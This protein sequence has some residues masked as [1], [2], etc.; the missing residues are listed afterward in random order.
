MSKTILVRPILFIF[1]ML[2]SFSLAEAKLEK[3]QNVDPTN[4]IWRGAQP[5]SEADYKELSEL[6]IKTIINLRWEEAIIAESKSQAEQRGIE[7][8]NVPFRAKL[9]PTEEQMQKIF[10]VLEDPAKQPVYLHCTLG[11]DRTGLVFALYR[12]KKQGW[13]IKKAYEE[14]LKFGF[15]VE[16]LPALKKF[17]LKHTDSALASE[18]HSISRSCKRVFF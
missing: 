12:V 2:L 6:G 14:W 7:F 11:K 9:G 1:F 17:F 18:S 5:K 16:A 10:S 8:V 13:D 4:H 15:S 3:L